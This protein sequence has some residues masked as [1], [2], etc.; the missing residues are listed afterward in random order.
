[1]IKYRLDRRIKIYHISVGCKV[2]LREDSEFVGHGSHNPLGVVGEVI[3]ID[4][5]DEIL[6]IGVIWPGGGLN[7]YAMKDLDILI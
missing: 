3:R 1:M 4:D 5:G 7:D 2:M 6:P